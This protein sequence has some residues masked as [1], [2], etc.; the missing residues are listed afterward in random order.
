M[1]PPPSTWRGGRCRA[2]HWDRISRLFVLES[3][4]KLASELEANFVLMDPSWY[5]DHQ[6]RNH[7]D[8]ERIGLAPS[9][10]RADVPAA[11]QIQENPVQG[12]RG[13]LPSHDGRSTAR[14]RLLFS[15][16]LAP[17]HRHEKPIAKIQRGDVLLEGRIGRELVSSVLPLLQAVEG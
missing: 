15:G 2:S 9:R 8:C 5:P 11:G 3:R 7:P 13:L 1:R 10:D 12:I 4:S 16:I 6:D 17:L 14:R